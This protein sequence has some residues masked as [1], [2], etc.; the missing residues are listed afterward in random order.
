METYT[1]LDNTKMDNVLTTSEQ[2][3]IDTSGSDSET[4]TPTPT[5]VATPIEPEPEPSTTTERLT[6]PLTTSPPTFPSN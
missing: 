4:P 6:T 1:D 2:G 5:Q 3:K